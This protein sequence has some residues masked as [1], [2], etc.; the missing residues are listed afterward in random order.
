MEKVKEGKKIELNLILFVSAFCLAWHCGLLLGL[1]HVL[2][3]TMPP[4]KLLL[5]F[6][7]IPKQ[8][9]CCLLLE[10]K[11]KSQMHLLPSVPLINAHE[12]KDYF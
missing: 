12:L 11:S 10:V 6:E 1:S 9:P 4:R 2:P 7:M 5:D 3:M 8:S